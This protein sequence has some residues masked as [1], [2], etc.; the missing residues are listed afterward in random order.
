MP[1]EVEEDY[2]IEDILIRSFQSEILER[3]TPAF[4]IDFLELSSHWDF[5]ASKK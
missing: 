1:F 4:K 2:L 5:K 3:Q